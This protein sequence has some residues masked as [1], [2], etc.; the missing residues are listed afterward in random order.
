MAADLEDL[1]VDQSVVEKAVKMVT[2]KGCRWVV[3]M[4]EQ[5]VELLG[6]CWGDDWVDLW[7]GNSVGKM[8]EKKA[9]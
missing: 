7:V 6:G 2:M 3:E 9:V 5:L 8:V 4:V 1:M